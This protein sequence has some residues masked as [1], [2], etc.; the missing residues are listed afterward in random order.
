MDFSKRNLASNLVK[1]YYIF[2]IGK[3][4]GK[5]MYVG[6]VLVAGSTEEEEY[7]SDLKIKIYMY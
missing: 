6:M 1:T 7:F 3:T 4:G 5:G 2:L